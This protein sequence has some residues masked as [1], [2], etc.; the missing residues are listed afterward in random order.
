MEDGYNKNLAVRADTTTFYAHKRVVKT[1]SGSG[2]VVLDTASER[3]GRTT[4][5]VVR[6]QVVKAQQKPFYVLLTKML[7]KP[8]LL[9]KC[10][11]EAHMINR[12]AHVTAAEAVL[13]KA[14]P[15]K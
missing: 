15:E 8:V 3:A 11:T 2:T 6:N 14:I 10:V 9:L 13:L 4:V 12:P 5:Q 1:S 7:K